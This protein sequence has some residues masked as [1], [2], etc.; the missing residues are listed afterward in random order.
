MNN[1]QFRS[2]IGQPFIVASANGDVTGDKIVDQIYLT[3]T[4]T[5]DSPFIQNITLHIRDGR[6]GAVTAFRFII[7]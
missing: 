7:M 3:G 6:T 1:S 2:A 5:A 4:K